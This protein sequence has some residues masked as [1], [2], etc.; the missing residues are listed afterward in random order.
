MTG[1]FRWCGNAYPYFHGAY[2]NT[3]ISERAV[4]V[5]IAMSLLN[6]SVCTLE[7][8]AVL[9]HYLPDWPSG[10]HTV[11]DL[12]ED[13][14]GVVNED[15]LTFEP[16][17][18]YDCIICISTLDHLNDAHE[19]KTAVRRMKSWLNRGG[20]LFITIPA[21]QPAEVGGGAWLDELVLS[22]ALGMMLARMDK[23][24][25]TGHIWE[26]VETDAAPL[27]YNGRSPFANTLYLLEWSR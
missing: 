12:Y 13:F 20:Y 8:G 15:V 5:S 9:P 17:V 3:R 16:E 21:G 6:Q 14:P 2:N 10:W 1:A 22:G 23:T 24:D 26:Q 25:P 7:V 4:E 27:A 11:I 18:L 19:V